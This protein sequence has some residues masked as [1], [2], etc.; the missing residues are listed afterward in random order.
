M[1]LD[2]GS[3]GPK[4]P[5]DPSKGKG[6]G[7][8]AHQCARIPGKS[9]RG[10]M[11]V[12]ELGEARVERER[13]IIIIFYIVLYLVLTD[14]AVMGTF[15]VQIQSALN[16]SGMQRFVYLQVTRAR[17]RQRFQ[18]AESCHLMKC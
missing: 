5:D 11:G 17:N 9:S 1:F 3:K 13:E 15:T 6:R 10:K 16:S 4:A 14:S 18:I 12:R 8:G 2:S 7:Y